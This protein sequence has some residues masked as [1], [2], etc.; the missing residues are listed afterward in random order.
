[1]K[2]RWSPTSMDE[3][4]AGIEKA[5]LS[6]KRDRGNWASEQRGIRRRTI[7]AIQA[8]IR[9]YYEMVA[10]DRAENWVAGKPVY[11]EAVGYRVGRLTHILIPKPEPEPKPYAV[12]EAARELVDALGAEQHRPHNTPRTYGAL[13]LLRAALDEESDDD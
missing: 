11:Y 12:R 7:A 10:V 5:G 13:N 8:Y 4:A 3:L 9:E 2:N 6:S 1:M